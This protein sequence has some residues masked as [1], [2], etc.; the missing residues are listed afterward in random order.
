VSFIFEKE[1]CILKRFMSLST[2]VLAATVLLGCDVK[3]RSAN[4]GTE[5]TATKKVDD[6][7]AMEF[8][9]GGSSTANRVDWGLP[10]DKQLHASKNLYNKPAPKLIVEKFIGEQPSFEGKFVLIDFWAT[11]CGPCLKAIP[12]L[13]SLAKAFPDDVVVLGI[14]SESEAT[15]RGLREAKIEYYSAVD[16]KGRTKKAIGVSGIPH[17]VVVDPSGTVCWQGYP[18]ENGFELTPEVIQERIDRYAGRNTK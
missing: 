17:V 18:F 7:V 5:Q 9:L 11:W 3:D 6:S 16:T 14:S 13:N 4:L 8:T 2:S 10:P 15:V 1:A 12:E